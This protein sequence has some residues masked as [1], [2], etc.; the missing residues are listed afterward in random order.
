MQ[1]KHDRDVISSFN[2]II[3]LQ[4]IAGSEEECPESQK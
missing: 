2:E 1:A 3:Q 4:A